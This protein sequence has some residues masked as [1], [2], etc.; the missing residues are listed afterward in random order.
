[1]TFATPAHQNALLA[2][3]FAFIRVNVQFITIDREVDLGLG[4]I[5]KSIVMFKHLEL[6]V[7][8]RVGACFTSCSKLLFD[9]IHLVLQYLHLQGENLILHLQVLHR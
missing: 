4:T 7:R 5:D 1:M 3:I 9:L 6:F 8:S 2:L